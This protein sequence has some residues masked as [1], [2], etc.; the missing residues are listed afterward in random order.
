MT[1][2]NWFNLVY[3]TDVFL[4]ST[5]G[6]DP[7]YYGT[8]TRLKRCVWCTLQN[9]LYWRDGVCCAKWV[10]YSHKAPI[11]PNAS[12]MRWRCLTV[13]RS[14]SIKYQA[15]KS[16]T[17]GIPT[18]LKK[19][20]YRFDKSGLSNP[21]IEHFSGYFQNIVKTVYSG[22]PGGPSGGASGGIRDPGPPENPE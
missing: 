19:H 22:S 2:C 13:Q 5:L 17:T 1:H 21:G 4:T 3:A 6:R 12:A 10:G 15:R 8:N 16:I 9:K 18:S 7:F 14:P 11:P 20:F